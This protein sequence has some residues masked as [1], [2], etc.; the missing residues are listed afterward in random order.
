M[1][2]LKRFI[3]AQANDYSRAFSEIQAG[4]KRT[5]WMWYI[6]PQLHGLGQSETAKFYAIK[7]LE[8]AEQFLNDKILGE[9]LINISK[10]LLKLKNTDA[11]S[12]MGNPDDMKLKSSMTLFASLKNSNPVF[13]EVLDKFYN[14]KS[15]LKTQKILGIL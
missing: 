15:D 2:D 14:G 4:K 7:D 8:E 5:H 3:D 6:F 9:R 10:E 13:K 11:N 1:A 12:I